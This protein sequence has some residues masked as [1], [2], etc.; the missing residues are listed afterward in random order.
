MK[1]IAQKAV[2]AAIT[3]AFLGAP[4]FA[5]QSGSPT[6]RT[7]GEK[8]HDAEIDKAYRDTVK[9]ESA[10]L[11]K[12]TKSDPWSDL[13]PAADNSKPDKSSTKK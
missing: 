1:T 7:D 2:M 13:R 11:G 8:K 4:A 3:L 12:Q 5:Q 6:A 9:R 10:A